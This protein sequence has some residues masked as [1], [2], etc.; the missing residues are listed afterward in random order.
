LSGDRGEQHHDERSRTGVT[1]R[2]VEVEHGEECGVD[3]PSLIDRD[4]ADSLAETVD[5]DGAELLDED[6]RGLATDV[7]LRPS[8]ARWEVVM[9]V[10]NSEPATPVVVRADRPLLDEA[11]LAAVVYLARYSGQTLA[12]YRADPRQFVQW[13]ADIEL[14]P[15]TASR[16]H[17]EL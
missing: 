8:T 1:R 9:S 13:C 10:F 7:E 14:A 4:P 5:V 11:Q 16:T 15:L 12:S 17:I 2:S 6:S 3:L